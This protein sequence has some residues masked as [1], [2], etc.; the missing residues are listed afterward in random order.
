MRKRFW[1]I[2]VGMWLALAGCSK[3]EEVLIPDNTAPPDETISDIVIESYINRTYITLLGRKPEDPEFAAGVTQ[4]RQNNVSAGNRTDF[5]NSVFAKPEYPQRLFDVGRQ[6]YLNSQDTTDIRDQVFIF[7]LL[8]QDVQYQALWPVIQDERDRLVAIL[9]VPTGLANGTVTVTEMHRRLVYN[10]IYDQ[11]NMGTQNF[12]IAMFQQF[13][14]RYP[15]DA[16]LAASEL[17]VDGL[18]SVIFF[19]TGNSKDEF[20]DIFL[21]SN[22]YY[23]GQV[24]DVYTR[25]LFREPDT[26]EL[27][28]LS[29]AYKGNGD[30]EALLLSVLTSDEYAGL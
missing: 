25:N 15:T 19:E 29:I 17:M 3:Q 1:V 2:G 8:L 14:F 6:L 24:R 13:L 28:S 5:V 16:E 9:E 26:Q 11:I 27:E 18:S 21:A 12:V 7:D 30:Y 23:E 20:I 10:Y 4:L 22:D